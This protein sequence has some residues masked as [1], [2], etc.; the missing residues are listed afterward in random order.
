MKD[1]ANPPRPSHIECTGPC[2][3]RRRATVVVTR[4]NAGKGAATTAALLRKMI[5][6]G[7]GAVV[8]VSTMAA[9]ASLADAPVV[10]VC[11]SAEPENG[12]RSELGALRQ[13]LYSLHF[14]RR[15]IASA[16]QHLSGRR[17]VGHR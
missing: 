15:L 17:H 10:T 1:G 7:S 13:R 16:A 4:R 6:R 9:S 14:L 2:D 5:T 8:N 11:A 3:T 12:A